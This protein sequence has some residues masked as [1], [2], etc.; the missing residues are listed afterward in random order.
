MYWLLCVWSSYF[1]LCLSIESVLL[2]SSEYLGCI[3][4]LCK[5]YPQEAYRSS[6]PDFAGLFVFS[7]LHDIVFP[8]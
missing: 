8:L 3:Q 7:P 6:L 4:V 5:G 1:A 2:L